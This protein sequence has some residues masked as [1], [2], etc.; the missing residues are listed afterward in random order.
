M[1][2]LLS[3]LARIVVLPVL[4]AVIKPFR[5]AATD[6]GVTCHFACEVTSTTDPPEK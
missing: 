5:T 4:F 2:V 1:P 3:L 6:F